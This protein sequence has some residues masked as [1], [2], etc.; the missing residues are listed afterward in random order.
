MN[1]PLVSVI[2]AVKDGERFLAAAIESVLAQDYPDYE[3]IV[4]DGHSVDRTADIA[5]SCPLV[6]F[7]EQKNHGVPGAYNEGIEA[8]RGEFVA[9]LS[10]D[11]LWAQDK[12]SVQIG[13][14][15]DHPEIDLT[16][17]RVKFFLQEGGPIPSGFRRELLEGEWVGYMME[18]LVVRKTVFETI[19]ELDA[20]LE[21]AE[22]A[23]W[24]SRAN[25]RGIRMQVIPRVLLY[26]R[27]HDANLTFNVPNVNK[28]L[29]HVLKRSIDRKHHH[30]R[31]STQFENG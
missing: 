29:L 11:D 28:I 17:A 7:V 19:G 12:L 20:S 31:R 26:K 16:I 2:V 25:D 18:T 14:M 8:A 13:Y 4:V 1:R 9:F 6:R 3:I 23:D 30:E 5:K 22:D 27:V 24:F 15:V 10:H 21:A